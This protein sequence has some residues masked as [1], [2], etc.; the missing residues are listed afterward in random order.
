[1]ATKRTVEAIDREIAECKEELTNVKGR[2]TEVYTRIVGY[3]RA[4]KN[5]NKGKKSEFKQRVCFEPDFVAAAKEEAAPVSAAPADADAPASFIYFTKK[6]CPNCPA[7]K[8]YV[9]KLGIKHTGYVVDTPE[10]LEKAR[11]YNV[12][13]VPTVIFFDAAGKELYRAYNVKEIKAKLE[14]PVAQAV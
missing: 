5:W 14:A 3:Y 8:E 9:E 2:E 6:T 10:G 1:M 7:V 4:V 11:E 12:F 13:A